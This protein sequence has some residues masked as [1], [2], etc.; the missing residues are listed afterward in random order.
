MTATE[1]K[2]EERSIRKSTEKLGL[3]VKLRVG[4]SNLIH[5]S[6]LPIPPEKLQMC[7][8][9]SESRWRDSGNMLVVLASTFC[10]AVGSQTTFGS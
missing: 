9:L 1:D 6:D 5:H 3:E 4:E 10:D 8:H 7:S 2:A